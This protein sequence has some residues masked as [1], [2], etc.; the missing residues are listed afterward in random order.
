MLQLEKPV[1]NNYWAHTFRACALQEKRF[2]HYNEDPV[3]PKEKK[4]AQD[5]EENIFG[6]LVCWVWEMEEK[7]Y[8]QGKLSFIQGRKK[9]A[10]LGKDS[11]DPVENVLWSHSSERKRKR[12]DAPG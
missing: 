9:K 10:F 8:S 5:N 4:V 12:K 7:E 2:M 3:Q 6:I 11:I 1:H